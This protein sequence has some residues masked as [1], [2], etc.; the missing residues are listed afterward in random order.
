MCAPSG[1]LIP[2]VEHFNKKQVRLKEGTQIELQRYLS[3]SVGFA[4]L[5]DLSDLPDLSDSSI[6]AIKK[7][8]DGPTDGPTDR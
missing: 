7:T 2:F 5:L 1:K 6:S 4:G 3:Y 8:Q